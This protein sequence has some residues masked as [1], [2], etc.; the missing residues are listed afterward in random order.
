MKKIEAWKTDD[1]KIWETEVM[2]E[3]HEHKLKAMKCFEEQYYYGM[4][5]CNRGLFEFIDSHRKQ[6]L[7]YYG[8]REKIKL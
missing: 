6:I 3:K 4:V 2:A 5:V 1:G 7:E 8:I